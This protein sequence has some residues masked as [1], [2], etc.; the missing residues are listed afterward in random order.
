MS[1]IAKKCLHHQ[2]QRKITV[3]KLDADTYYVKLFV[4]SCYP[5]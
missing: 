1:K 5:K 4:E 2:Y 3:E